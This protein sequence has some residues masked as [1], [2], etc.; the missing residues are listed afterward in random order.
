MSGALRIHYPARRAAKVQTSQ[1]A[2]VPL[3]RQSYFSASEFD[4]PEKIAAAWRAAAA[5]DPRVLI[6]LSEE[7]ENHPRI[8]GPLRTRRLAVSIKDMR[9]EPGDTSQAAIDAAKVWEKRLVDLDVDEVV[10]H[11]QGTSIRPFE[12]VEIIREGFQIVKLKIWGAGQFR[13]DYQESGEQFRVLTEAEPD[14]GE[15]INPIQWIIKLSHEKSYTLIPRR[16]TI[17][18]LAGQWFMMRMFMMFWASFGERFGSPLIKGTY[19]V[20][21]SDSQIRKLKAAVQSLGSDAAAVVEEGMLLEILEAAKNSGRD[22]FSPAIDRLAADCAVQILG[23]TLTSAGSDQGAGSFSLGQVHDSVRDD[24][25]DADGES[26][27]KVL[28]RMLIAPQHRLEYGELVPAPQLIYD[29]PDD[30]DIMVSQRIIWMGGELDA[31]DEY[32]R[33]GR[34]L[35]ESMKG[36]TLKSPNVDPFGA[37]GGASFMTRNQQRLAE[38]YRGYVRPRDEDA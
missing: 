37:Q 7:I 21:A 14:R 18:G 23:G 6:R 25:R 19:P 24:L 2:A 36:K 27:A 12:A 20:G 38:A 32:R 16:G 4:T 34:K 3:N 33:W 5:G 10:S 26:T 11:L 17:R 30:R 15:V 1:V 13:F 31:E 28:N 22:V 8:G 29:G 35:P 9:I